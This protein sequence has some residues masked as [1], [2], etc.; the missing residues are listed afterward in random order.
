MEILHQLIDCRVG[1]DIGGWTQAIC[2]EFAGDAF[3]VEALAARARAQQ[4]RP[5]VEPKGHSPVA[6]FEH[7]N[8]RRCDHW[9]PWHPEHIGQDLA[10]PRLGD[11]QLCSRDLVEDFEYR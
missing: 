7:I 1:S 10:M 5:I 8:D 3:I 6:P 11:D 2:P 9:Y 4:N